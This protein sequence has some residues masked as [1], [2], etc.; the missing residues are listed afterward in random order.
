MPL[1]FFNLL[2]L[3]NPDF[4][5]TI[6][7]LLSSFLLR[8]FN[9]KKSKSFILMCSIEVYWMCLNK[10]NE[11]LTPYYYSQFLTILKDSSIL[12]WYFGKHSNS[13]DRYYFNKRRSFK[14]LFNIQ[15]FGST[16]PLEIK[17]N[18]ERGIL[19]TTITFFLVS[20]DSLLF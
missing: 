9:I 17:F 18:L 15:N 16:S 13:R 20:F 10:C 8:M 2:M 11:I 5:R 6:F 7:K 4:R 14:L 3:V 19:K 12:K 1:I